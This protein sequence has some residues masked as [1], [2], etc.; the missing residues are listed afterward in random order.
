MTVN[1]AFAEFLL[2]KR[3]SNLSAATITDYSYMIGK[4]VDFLGHDLPVESLSDAKYLKDYVLM[5]QSRD[6]LGKT[7]HT[8]VKQI[9]VF[10]SY[11]FDRHLIGSNPAEELQI[12][13]E[14][15]LPLVL[16]EE[17]IE[18]LFQIES[19]RDR[20]LVCF[21]LDCGVRHRELCNIMND[22]I[23]D[24]RLYVHLGKGRKDRLVP[25]S[26]PLLDMIEAYR[27]DR[28]PNT[29]HFFQT[30]DGRPLSYSAIH[31]I[32]YRLKKK[33]G[34][35]RLAPHLLRHTYGTYYIESGGDIKTLQLLLGHS[36][37]K[38]TETYVHIA[39]LLHVEKYAQ[40][41]IFNRLKENE[42]KKNE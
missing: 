17:E 11:L 32:F 4:F 16:T 25:L 33:T 41:S 35:A 1:E 22:D 15:K 38:T 36:D 18:G 7:I 27:L 37:V 39:Q 34:V 30:Y 42:G 6:L 24:G 40:Y 10:Y 21:V 8:Y 14:K 31:S 28:D 5:L 29:L 19:L 23:S 26:A 9:K 3:V 2:D 20:L 13:F 12:K